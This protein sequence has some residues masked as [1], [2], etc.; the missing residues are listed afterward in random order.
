MEC[1]NV[2]K[3]FIKIP[4]SIV[5]NNA[6][7]NESKFIYVAIQLSIGLYRNRSSLPVNLTGIMEI[8]GLEVRANNTRKSKSAINYLIDKKLISVYGDFN[9]QNEIDI[10][11]LKPTTSFHIK[12][13]NEYPYSKEFLINFNKDEVDKDIIQS[14]IDFTALYVE[15]LFKIIEADFKGS[16]SN[17]L[18]HYLVVISRALVGDK[19]SRYSSESIGNISK[20]SSLS[21][22]TIQGYS[23]A[24]FDLKLLFKMT[25]QNVSD[26]GVKEHNI[27]TR[28]DDNLYAGYAMLTDDYFKDKKLIKIGV[29]PVDDISRKKY[30]SAVRKEF[31]LVA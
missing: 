16:K 11:D 17:L 20:Y 24:L 7:S 26:A 25:L 6:I 19:S 9:L 30:L 13:N 15:D 12:I 3:E 5:R 29:T 23:S 22:K 1:G 28:W 14:G 4:N 18:A 27:Y 31:K 10:E 2:E 8:M 21:N